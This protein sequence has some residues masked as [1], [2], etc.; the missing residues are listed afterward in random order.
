MPLQKRQ[1]RCA[2]LG[3]GATPEEFGTLN[4]INPM[5]FGGSG[6]CIGGSRT[7]NGG[8]HDP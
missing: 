5:S 3:T 4:P 2:F 6:P 8:A 1:P 7:C